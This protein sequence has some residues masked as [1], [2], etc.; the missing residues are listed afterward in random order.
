MKVIATKAGFYNGIK[1]KGDMFT[2]ISRLQK[3]TKDQHGVDIQK[4]FSK[5]WMQEVKEQAKPAKVKS[6]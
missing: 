6:K 2:L 5:V 3:G 1:K 4:Q